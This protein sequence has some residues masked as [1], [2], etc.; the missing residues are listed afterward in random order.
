MRHKLAETL[1]S[2]EA[3]GE[4]LAVAREEPGPL[5]IDLARVLAGRAARD[6]A[7][8]GQQILAGIGFTRDHDFHR[9]LFSSFD[10][11]GLYG[12]TEGLT[13]ELGRQLLQSRA[14][15]RIIDL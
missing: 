2:V 6:A 4:A 5:S 13:K 12:T 8:H 9:Y 11:D 7:R 14:V 3:A 15:P 1:V 10:T